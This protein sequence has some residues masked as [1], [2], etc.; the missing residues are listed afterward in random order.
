MY[1]NLFYCNTQILSSGNKG[2]VFPSSFC[3]TFA[4]KRAQ[5][6]ASFPFFLCHP[7]RQTE[8]VHK[9]LKIWRKIFPVFLQHPKPGHR[10]RQRTT[11][12]HTIAE[13]APF[14]LQPVSFPAFPAVVCFCFPA[15]SRHRKNSCSQILEELCQ[16]ILEPFSAVIGLNLPYSCRFYR[17]FSTFLFIA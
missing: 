10:N 3:G 2:G 4:Q 1:T 12:T 6:R 7:L 8:G 15:V 5:R 11:P 14:C 17:Y 9:K 16:R 13:R